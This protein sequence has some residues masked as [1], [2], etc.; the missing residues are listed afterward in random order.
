MAKTS[1]TPVQLVFKV[2]RSRVTH[3]SYRAGGRDLTFDYSA[4][5]FEIASVHFDNDKVFECSIATTTSLS[6]S[7]SRNLF[8]ATK[9]PLK[10]EVM[11]D[12]LFLFGEKRQGAKKEKKTLKHAVTFLKAKFG[13]NIPI[14]NSK[15]TNVDQ[16]GRGFIVVG[17]KLYTGRYEKYGDNYEKRESNGVGLFDTDRRITEFTLNL[18]PV[19]LPDI[20][21]PIKALKN[22]YTATDGRKFAWNQET[23]KFEEVSVKTA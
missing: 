23:R 18:T 20:G 16:W 21:K 7:I 3:V 1:A 4:G 13:G 5:V 11:N 6:A 10:L 22:E 14:P 8:I 12:S 15:Y 17:D 9:E 2:R 19:E